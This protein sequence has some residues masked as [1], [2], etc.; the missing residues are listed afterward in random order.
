MDVWKT[1][2]DV[3]FWVRLS[4]N[5]YYARYFL[6]FSLGQSL[7]PSEVSPLNQAPETVLIDHFILEFRNWKRSQ[8]RSLQYLLWNNYFLPF[9]KQKTLTQQSTF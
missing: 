7:H 6:L 1:V 5:I 4:K 9:F 8:N 2:Q 3:T